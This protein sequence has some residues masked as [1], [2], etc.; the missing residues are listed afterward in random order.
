MLARLLSEKNDQKVVTT[1]IVAFMLLSAD[2][3]QKLGDELDK[4]RVETAKKKRSRR[5]DR[6]FN[7]TSSLGRSESGFW[8]MSN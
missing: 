2:Q 1:G 6:G 7:C 3:I 5:R 8:F 4:A